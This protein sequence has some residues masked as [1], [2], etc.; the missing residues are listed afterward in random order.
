MKVLINTCFGGFSFS[1]AAIQEYNSRKS[2][3][4]PEATKYN[5]SRTDPLMIEVVE[6][7]GSAANGEHAELKVVEIPDDV[8][9][10]IHYYDGNEHVAEEHRTWS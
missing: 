1:D 6:E 9:W 4:A 2:P 7:L 5:H 8:K 10:Y 3:N